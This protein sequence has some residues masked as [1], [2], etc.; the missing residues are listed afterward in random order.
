[1]T[2][3][4]SP[5]CGCCSAWVEHARTAGYDLTVIESDQ[6]ELMRQKSERGVDDA[7]AGCHTVEV[8]GYTIEGHVPM[9][10]IA[11]LLS[12]RPDAIGLAVP[13]MPSGSAGMDMDGRVD[14][15]DV[16]LF[17]AIGERSVFASYS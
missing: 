6:E 1:M 9:E 3:Y 12:D 17:S 16:I 8:D 11:R 15:F 5:T 13:G 2:V 14:P 7:L 4:L 10:D